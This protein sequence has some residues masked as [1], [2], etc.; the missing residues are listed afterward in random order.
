MGTFLSC[1]FHEK[2][3]NKVKFVNSMMPSS[4]NAYFF[5]LCQRIL[6]KRQTNKH[7]D[8][9]KSIT[10]TNKH[11]KRKRTHERQYMA[12]PLQHESTLTTVLVDKHVSRV[13]PGSRRSHVLLSEGNVRYC[14]TFRH[15]RGQ[16][17]GER[18]RRDG[19][20]DPFLPLSNGCRKHD[21][22]KQLSGGQLINQMCQ[23][24]VTEVN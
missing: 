22:N 6:L 14:M 24:L 19:G 2:R 21:V 9:T 7:K 18:T 13:I 10:H 4:A 8:K 1:N 5:L 17:W 20:F 11:K 3:N 12:C 16:R 23:T 15:T